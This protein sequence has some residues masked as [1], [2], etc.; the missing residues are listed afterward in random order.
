MVGGGPSSSKKS[1]NPSPPKPNVAPSIHRLVPIS[2]THWTRSSNVAL[3]ESGDVTHWL[4]S[5]SLGILTLSSSLH[6]TRRPL[7][8][9]LRTPDIING[10]RQ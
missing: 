6:V 1:K 8:G 3:M 2:V 7:N 4:T 9:P 10:N 5:L